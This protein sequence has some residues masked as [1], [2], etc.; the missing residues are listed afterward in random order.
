MAV[1]RVHTSRSAWPQPQPPPAR[2]ADT[3][4]WTPPPVL[5]PLHL[6]ATTEPMPAS[7]PFRSVPFPFRPALPRS[8]TE[9]ITRPPCLPASP[10]RARTTGASAD[11]E[12]PAI[13]A[14]R[15]VNGQHARTNLAGAVRTMLS[16]LPLPPPL[17]HGD[18]SRVARRPP[19][20]NHR[21]PSHRPSRRRTGP[22][23]HQRHLKSRP[24][25]TRPPTPGA[26][27]S[28]RRDLAGLLL[29]GSGAERWRWRRCR[30]RWMRC[31]GGRPCCGTRCGGA[32]G[33]RTAWSPSSAPSTTASPR[34]RPPCAPPRFAPASVSSPAISNASSRHQ[35]VG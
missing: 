6:H 16:L 33:T 26:F 14:V 17:S 22:L 29:R 28:P 15:G 34:S 9:R 21:F 8:H 31:R 2:A 1:D 20:P 7:R 27:S 30:R 35:S 32:R 3:N 24:S 5:H 4:S 13:R 23:F 25:L 10:S 18:T 19:P 12:P 11:E